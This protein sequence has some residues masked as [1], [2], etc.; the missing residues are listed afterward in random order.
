[1]AACEFSLPAAIAMQ[2]LLSLPNLQRVWTSCA[3][4]EP[5]I[6]YVK[7]D[8]C[9]ANITHPEVHCLQQG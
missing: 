5:S 3:F 4:F 9:S 7:W 2:Q 6:S 8:C 1:M